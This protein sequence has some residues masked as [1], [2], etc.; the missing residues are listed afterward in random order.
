MF[1]TWSAGNRRVLT[2]IANERLCVPAHVLIETFSV[3]TRLPEPHRASAEAA[4]EYLRAE[5]KSVITLPA[6]EHLK[7]LLRA[8]ELGISGGKIYDA[9]IGVTAR[10]NKVE[11]L[12]RDRRAKET[13]D[14]LDV[15]ARYV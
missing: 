8:V 11:L 14:Q 6:I 5:F 10:Q 7:L 2:A 12:T 9:L 13:Y 1:A 4:S 3:L 15:E